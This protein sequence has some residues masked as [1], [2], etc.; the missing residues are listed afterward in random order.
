MKI[1]TPEQFETEQKD[2]LLYLGRIRAADYVWVHRLGRDNSPAN[3]ERLAQDLQGDILVTQTV[4]DND[5]SWAS[6]YL[7]GKVG[8]GDLTFVSAADLYRDNSIKRNAQYIN[9]EHLA[10]I[11]LQ[12]DDLVSISVDKNVESYDKYGAKSK[13]L[14]EATKIGADYVLLKSNDCQEL[15][16][17]TR[18]DILNSSEFVA[19]SSGRL[20]KLKGAKKQNEIEV[21][22]SSQ[23]T[24]YS[25]PQNPAALDYAK[26]LLA[27]NTG[28]TI[29]DWKKP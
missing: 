11:E 14:E 21:S 10:Q 16:E 20:Y 24:N 29:M 19:I 23:S 9:D 4:N 7:R 8:M 5:W 28:G 12:L 18:Y 1:I 26:K 27:G 25:F 6:N 22:S 17:F 3:L 13:L 2:N 15:T